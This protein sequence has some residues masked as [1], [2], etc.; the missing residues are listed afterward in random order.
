MISINYPQ[1]IQH[2]K[3]IRNGMYPATAFYAQAATAEN[4]IVAFRKKEV[5]R[6]SSLPTSETNDSVTARWYMHTGYGTTRLV[7]YAIL[8]A[9]D[10]GSTDPTVT[11][12]VTIPGGAT[13]TFSPVMRAMPSD[14]PGGYSVMRADADVAANTTYS[15][16][17]TGA[18]GARMMSLVIFEESEGYLDTSVDY[19]NDLAPAS[20]MKIYD[21]HRSDLLPGLSNMWRRNGALQLN[22]SRED[23]A[24]RTRTSATA[25]NLIDNTETGTPTADSSGWTLDGA[26]RTTS[27]R[28]VI[29]VRLAAYGSMAVGVGVVRLI[30]TSGNT[31]CAVDIDSATPGWFTTT[32]NLVAAGTKF[33]APQ[34]YGNGTDEVSISSLSILEYEA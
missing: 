18:A 16:L 29:P 3:Y 23:G 11:I 25:I 9:P 6:Q 27:T 17:V 8:G 15:G 14:T 10:V 24:S 20:G 5:F 13:T 19:Y 4:H 2:R 26:Y 32:G 21:V 28:A 31:V 34:F 12:A 33:Y 1:L 30:D 7:A 22:W